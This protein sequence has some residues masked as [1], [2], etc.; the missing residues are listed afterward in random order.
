VSV[1]TGAKLDERGVLITPPVTITNTTNG[2]SVDNGAA[3]TSSGG[4]SFL[5]ITEAAASDTYTITLEGSTTGSFSGEQSTL[6]T[7]T[8][9]ASDDGSVE[10]L[11][12]YKNA[13]GPV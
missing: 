10:D 4:A 11:M 8:L 6:A 1:F 7:F 3:T 5:H 12:Y 13:S 2:G 9:D